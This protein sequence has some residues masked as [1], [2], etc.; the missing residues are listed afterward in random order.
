MTGE[1]HP[2]VAFT[3]L[4]WHQ[5]R[6]RSRGSGSSAASMPE[7]FPYQTTLLHMSVREPSGFVVID[8]YGDDGYAVDLDFIS[9]TF[10]ADA[11]RCEVFTV[12]DDEEAMQAL[13]RLR[14][15]KVPQERR[16]PDA[17][18]PEAIAAAIAAARSSAGAP[19]NNHVV[20]LTHLPRLV[21]RDA[22]VARRELAAHAAE[23]SNV[24]LQ[25]RLDAPWGWL[26]LEPALTESAW[27]EEHVFVRELY[28][29][30]GVPVE[31]K[32]HTF[33]DR[34]HETAIDRLAS[35]LDMEVS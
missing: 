14:T 10:G 20:G 9:G 26:L 4:P 6:L 12:A 29:G 8:V 28:R 17:D 7:N 27:C 33:I 30:F 32:L 2:T 34:V 1:R 11:V 18:D 23:S 24:L 21:P 13:E 15:T 25:L 16:V 5:T 35:Q 22:A 3:H 31:A 19:L